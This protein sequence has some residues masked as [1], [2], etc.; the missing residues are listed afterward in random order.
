MFILLVLLVFF[1]LLPIPTVWLHRA[2]PQASTQPGSPLQFSLLSVSL[3]PRRQFRGDLWHILQCELVA[4]VAWVVMTHRW[5][6]L[7]PAKL[8]PVKQPHCFILFPLIN[9]SKK[10]SRTIPISAFCCF[11]LPFLVINKW[12]TFHQLL[13]LWAI[14]VKISFRCKTVHMQNPYGKILKQ[15][16]AI[17]A[18]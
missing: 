16:T 15:I 5:G 13:S 7:S 2:H 8:L 18:F 12:K 11:T 6:Y 10:R 17:W 9:W 3:D 1:F 4:L 14:W